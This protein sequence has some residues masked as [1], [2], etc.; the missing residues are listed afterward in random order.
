[1]KKGVTLYLNPVS[2][3]SLYFHSSLICE[4]IYIYTFFPAYLYSL[5]PLESFLLVTLTFLLELDFE[6]LTFVPIGYNILSIS[7]F[8]Q[9]KYKLLCMS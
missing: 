5:L 3:F 2:I 4:K 1:M 6:N 8:I 7:D 9:W